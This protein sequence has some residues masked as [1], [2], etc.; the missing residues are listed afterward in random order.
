MK[1][2]FM[3]HAG[4]LLCLSLLCVS[5]LCVQNSARA[6]DV[7][8]ALAPAAPVAEDSPE[9]K[10]TIDSALEEYRLG[11]FTEARSL[12]E[13]AHTLDPNAR[14]LR[15][16]GMV[17]FELRHYVRAAELLEASLAATHKP[18]TDD[19][20]KA[21]TELLE[22]TRQFIASYSLD[23]APERPG[24]LLE[25][26]GKAVELSSEKR[27]VLEAGEHT[28]RVSAPDVVARELHI[29]VRGGEQQTLRIELEVKDSGPA[30]AAAAPVPAATAA[31]PMQPPAQDG[32]IARPYAGLGV[33]LTSVGGVAVIAGSVLGALAL[34]Q[35]NDSSTRDDGKADRARTLALASDVSIGAGVVSVAVGIVLLMVR[36]RPTRDAS[37]LTQRSTRLDTFGSNLRLRF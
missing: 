2:A 10:R 35:A 7:R 20:K 15:G 23:V 28:L 36:E 30:K 32:P 8:P 4:L 31:E 19:Q 1:H 9:Y 17:E 25:I 14:T 34:A 13:H 37:R 12:F 22:R 11:H 16:R 6:D 3:K 24:L 29:D 21:V 18:L 33:A 5:L 27:L 26:D